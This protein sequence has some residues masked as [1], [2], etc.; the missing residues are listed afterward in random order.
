MARYRAARGIVWDPMRFEASWT[1]FENWI[2][3]ADGDAVGTLRLLAEGDALAIRDLQLRPD[4]Q[5][6][7]HGTWAIAQARRMARARGARVLRLR[8]Y[9]DNPAARLYARMG[10]VVHDEIDGV[11]HMQWSRPV[12]RACLSLG[13]NLEPERYLCSG[14]AA[15][16]ERF[17]LEAL[18]APYRCPAVG[19][20]GPDFLNAAAVVA[21][22]L[23]AVALDAW[24]HALE[25]AHGRDR[26][27]PRYASR[28]LDVDI[29][30][31][32]DAVITGPG[33]LVVPRPELAQAFVLKPLAAIAP[34]WIDP[35]SG[36]TLAT[37]WATSPERGVPCEVATVPGWPVIEPWPGAVFDGG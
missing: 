18:S 12:H 14:L 2:V 26:T 30:L 8:V 27:A 1:A 11:L 7:G 28:T 35:R 25:D 34:D 16:A 36:Q 3:L 15:I 33:N 5:R 29:V 21:C 6:R 10:F 37:R 24:L 20:E 19:F 23:D 22:D 32:D 31:F 17:E 4:A 13:S 9:A